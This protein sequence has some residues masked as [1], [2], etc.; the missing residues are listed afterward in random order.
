MYS[1][2]GKKPD[3]NQGEA[4][5]NKIRE[6]LAAQDFPEG[7]WGEIE[8]GYQVSLRFAKKSFTNGE[9]ITAIVLV[10]NT[11]NQRLPDQRMGYLNDIYMNND[12]PAMLTVTS[13]NGQALPAEPLDLT[14]PRDSAGVMY[15]APHTQRKYLEQLNNRYHLTNGVYAVCASV[16]MFY[17]VPVSTNDNNLA[18]AFGPKIV[19]KQLG[20]DGQHV[21]ESF[22]LKSAEAHLQISDE[23]TPT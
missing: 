11:L 13:S 23:P 20:P 5:T 12:G 2:Y 9:P 3:L 17:D 14:A 18:S 7:N 1:G 16:K 10:R 6:C 21:I 8:A 15:L 19:M 22:E 4:A